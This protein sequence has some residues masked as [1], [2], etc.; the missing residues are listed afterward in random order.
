MSFHKTLRAMGLGLA[1]GVA[2]MLPAQADNQSTVE[3]VSVTG[4]V[5]GSKAQGF[6]VT[7]GDL[8]VA[9]DMAD[10]VWYN[11]ETKLGDGESVTVYGT[12]DPAAGT[13]QIDADSLY[14]HSRKTFYFSQDSN[15]EVGYTLYGQ[16]SDYQ[17]GARLNLVG[18]VASVDDTGLA[19]NTGSEIIEVDAG[20][21]DRFNGARFA[22]IK[23]GD[24]VAIAGTLDQT[25]FAERRLVARTVLP[26]A[27]NDRMSTF[28][29]MK[30]QLRMSP[31][32]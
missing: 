25:F 28:L 11:T 4:E 5:T 19:L 6:T 2:A 12:L 20:A 27:V 3:R 29:S 31:R 14:V 15:R 7:D 8:A 24:V 30:E 23:R 22:S 9:I 16:A 10:W 13:A 1:M 26:V 21:L 18:K 32:G 17:D